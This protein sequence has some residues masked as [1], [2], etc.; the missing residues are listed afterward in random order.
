[1]CSAQIPVPLRFAASVS[2][3]HG[4][5]HPPAL[6]SDERPH[7]PFGHSAKHSEKVDEIALPGAVGAHQH[8]ESAELK[9]WKAENRFEAIYGD[10]I[11]GSVHGF[12]C[13]LWII[14]FP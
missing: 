10:E 12:P 11:E 7:I 14:H 3:R 2:V 4:Q 8:I 5:N 13:R 9:P 1:M 6:L